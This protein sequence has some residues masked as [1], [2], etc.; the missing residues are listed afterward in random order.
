M[1]LR[2]HSLQLTYTTG[3]MLQNISPHTWHCLGKVLVLR[4]KYKL[5]WKCTSSSCLRSM[6]KKPPKHRSVIG[7]QNLHRSGARLKRRNTFSPFDPAGPGCPGLPVT[8]CTTQY[9]FILVKKQWNT[10]FLHCSL[11]FKSCTFL[12]SFKPNYVSPPGLNTSL[13]FDTTAVSFW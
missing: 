6:L 7:L 8:P 4:H 5:M 9:Q 3:T 11:V 12:R 1:I 2:E 13:L 10:V